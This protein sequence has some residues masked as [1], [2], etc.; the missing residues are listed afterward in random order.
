MGHYVWKKMKK[1]P[2]GAGNISSAYGN[3]KG[4]QTDRHPWGNEI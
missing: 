2:T 1:K 3:C 4:G